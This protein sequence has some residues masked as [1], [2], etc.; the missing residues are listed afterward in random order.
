MS[1]R[2]APPIED[3]RAMG[4]A[5]TPILRK[6]QKLTSSFS[7]RRARSQRI[8]A[9][10]PV[11]ERFGPR[12]TP[13]RTACAIRP[14]ACAAREGASG[15]E[16]E[17]EIVDEIVRYANNEAN[18]QCSKQRE[19]LRGGQPSLREIESP[20]PFHSV[21]HDEKPCYQYRRSPTDLSSEADG[22]A[23]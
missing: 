7:L 9:S 23:S 2:M 3:N 16:A 10:E 21:D 19:L 22:I 1:I 12:L 6:R 5:T 8:V 13:I 17:R 15:D 20:H 11:T 4:I 18:D 14:F